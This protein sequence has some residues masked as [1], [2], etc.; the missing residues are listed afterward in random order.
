MDAGSGGLGKCPFLTARVSPGQDARS[1]PAPQPIGATDYL[2]PQAFQQLNLTGVIEIVRDDS[3]KQRERRLRGADFLVEDRWVEIL[4]RRSQQRMHLVKQS[5]VVAP[6]PPIRALARKPVG[7]RQRKR[8]PRLP[9]ETTTDRVL[10]VR[11]VNHQLLNVV[12]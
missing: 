2:L 6:L 1:A 4:D 9:C 12:S 7:A 8:P 10:P 5:H 11:R 3:G